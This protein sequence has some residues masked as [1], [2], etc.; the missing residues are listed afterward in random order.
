MPLKREKKIKKNDKFEFQ[1]IIK[2]DEKVL[3]YFENESSS[4]LPVYINNN[5]SKEKVLK[6]LLSSTKEPGLK[7]GDRIFTIFNPP[8]F[9]IF[10]FF[11]FF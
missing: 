3:N 7:P 1:T 10:I 9:L 8:G 5:N 4:Y 2:Q 11:I 6:K